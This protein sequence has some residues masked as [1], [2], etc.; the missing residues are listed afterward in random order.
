[1]D[2]D[3]MTLDELNAAGYEHRM[4]LLIIRSR[5]TPDMPAAERLELEQQAMAH[6]A[7]L[8]VIQ[9]LRT[10]R[11]LEAE[12]MAS[13][14]AQRVAGLSQEQF[15]RLRQAVRVGPGASETTLHAPDAEG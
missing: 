2:Y 10:E 14:F 6:R 15:D 3:S 12:L 13:E 7:H 1:M 4:A 8:N 11:F 5:I 9:P